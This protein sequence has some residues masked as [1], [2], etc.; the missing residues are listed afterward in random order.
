MNKERFFLTG[1]VLMDNFMP[2][3][4]GIEA[5]AAI[6]QE[7]LRNGRNDGPRILG[8]TGNVSCEDIAQF[9]QAGCDDV[10]AKPLRLTHLKNLLVTYGLQPAPSS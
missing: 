3:M 10:L 8:L 4:N 6:R 5:V 2:R 9:Q 1:Q 7:D